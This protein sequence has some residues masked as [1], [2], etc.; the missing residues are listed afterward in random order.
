[1]QAYID[2][3]DAS[4]PEFIRAYMDVAGY[5]IK[6]GNA[7]V[8]EAY[9]KQFENEGISTEIQSTL[10]ELSFFNNGTIAGSDETWTTLFGEYT[11]LTELIDA[12]VITYNEELQ[13]WVAT[14]VEAL[15]QFHTNLEAINDFE[16][17]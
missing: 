13:Q 5:G 14:S 16:A 15:Q 12:G 1:M 17:V 2:N 8:F 10:G 4:Y 9:Q 7:L 3:S 6:E 11:D